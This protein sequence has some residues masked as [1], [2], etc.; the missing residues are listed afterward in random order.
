MAKF[1]VRNQIVF[2]APARVG[3]L[4]DVTDRLEGK[5]VNILAVRGYDEGD[6]GV[7]LIY[8]DDSRMAEEALA[9]LEG[10]VRTV[11]MIVGEVA[12]TPGQ[13]A[14]I[15]RAL[16]NANINIIQVHSTTSDCSDARLV[17]ETSDDVRALDVLQKV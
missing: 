17:I 9:T 6:E 5:A 13:L 2:R 4:A 7:V 11:P 16:A 10:T 1:H 15:S 12:N 3:L 14:A 8:P